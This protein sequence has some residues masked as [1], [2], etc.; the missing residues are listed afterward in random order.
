MSDNSTVHRDTFWLMCDRVIANGI[1]RTIYSSKLFPECVVKV[2]DNA[3]MFQNIREWE[4]WKLVEGTQFA[5]WFAPCRWISPT[6]IVLVME[7][8]REPT[9]K[10]YPD[11][12]PAFLSDFKKTNYGMY[13]SRLVCHD[14]GTNWLMNVG[15]TTRMQRV[16]EWYEA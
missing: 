3:L 15:L 2:E 13:K 14:Y 10:Q 4:T 11:K 16:Q 6:G 12:M 5:R 9:P 8:T 7:R 1:S